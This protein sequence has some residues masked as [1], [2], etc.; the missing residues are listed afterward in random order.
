MSDYD[1]DGPGLISGGADCTSL[2]AL[3]QGFSYA[4]PAEPGLHIEVDYRYLL[5]WLRF[6]APRASGLIGAACCASHGK[7]PF[8]AFVYDHGDGFG[9]AVHAENG[10]ALDAYSTSL[11][12]DLIKR[13][14]P[15]TDLRALP[16]AK[17]SAPNRVA[18]LQRLLAERLSP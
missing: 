17:P 5:G 10:G 3:G 11:V 14:D 18:E 2:A 7:A 6:D 1:L 12:F 15:E 9:S 8:R 16:P 13:I 4:W